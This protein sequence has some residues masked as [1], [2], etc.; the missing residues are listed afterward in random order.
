MEFKKISIDEILN[1]HK[2]ET[3]TPHT[4]EKINKE[5]EEKYQMWMNEGRF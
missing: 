5:Y 1:E 3:L 2:N 4:I